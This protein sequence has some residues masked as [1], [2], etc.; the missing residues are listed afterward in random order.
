MYAN[1]KNLHNVEHSN[2]TLGIFLNQI[3]QHMEET[4][5]MKYHM[6]H[7]ESIVLKILKNLNPKLQNS[8]A[9]CVTITEWT[10]QPLRIMF[11][12]ITYVCGIIFT[13]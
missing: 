9:S 11:I 7:S 3:I 6:K 10:L 13:F 4:I 5:F 2:S 12:G 8:S 1:L